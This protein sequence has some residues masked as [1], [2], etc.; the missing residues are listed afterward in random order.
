MITSVLY[1]FRYRVF[2]ALLLDSFS[3]SSSFLQFSFSIF[4]TER[5]ILQ[6][7]IF[8]FSVKLKKN[9]IMH[10]FRNINVALRSMFLLL[11]DR[12]DKLDKLDKLV[13]SLHPDLSGTNF[14][15]SI[16]LLCFFV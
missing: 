2:S 9:M 7:F 1:Q 15:N 5:L 4:C 10:S 12:L 14:T 16:N 8:L 6:Q 3:V 11:L 13:R